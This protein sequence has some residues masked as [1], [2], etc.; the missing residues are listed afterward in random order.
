[1]VCHA[2]RLPGT[3]T[4]RLNADHLFVRGPGSR[5]LADHGPHSARAGAVAAASELCGG[6]PGTWGKPLAPSG[7]SHSSEC[8]RRYHRVPDP[9]RA[10]D[11][12]LRILP[13]LPGPGRS[14]ADGQLGNTDCRRRVTAQPGAHLLVAHRFS[15]SHARD[16]AAL[17]EFPR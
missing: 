2:F 4:C 3:A 7:P 12:P 1:M 5:F 15:R 14:T 8:L 6:Q 16:H 13:E 11:Y 17:L 10:L 9:D